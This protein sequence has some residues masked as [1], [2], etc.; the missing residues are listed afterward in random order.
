MKTREPFRLV[1]PDGPALRL[2]R[3][4]DS[5]TPGN[6]KLWVCVQT[7]DPANAGYVRGFPEGRFHSVR[8]GTRGEARAA[9]KKILGVPE[10]QRV[11]DG[12]DVYHV[13]VERD[14]EHQPI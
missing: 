5:R 10:R 4:Y 3:N 2:A 1:P 9:L 14:D 8:A 7:K 11:P 6:L 13:V 12:W